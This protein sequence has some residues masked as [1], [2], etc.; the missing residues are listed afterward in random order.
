MIIDP[1][2]VSYEQ[3]L[4]NAKSYRSTAQRVLHSPETDVDSN[5]FQHAQHVALF[6]TKRIHKLEGLIIEGNGA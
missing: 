1:D 4:A 6:E 5:I 3:Q 2:K